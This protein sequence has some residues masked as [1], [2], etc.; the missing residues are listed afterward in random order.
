[1]S[2]LVGWI[3][4]GLAAS[5]GASLWPFRRGLLGIAMNIGAGMAGAVGLAYVGIALGLPRRDPLTLV[6]AGVGA[7]VM[8]VVAHG[9]WQAGTRKRNRDAPEM[10]SRP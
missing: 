5:L 8:L 1:M 3:F 9:I 6:F 7:F 2:Y 4:I 10:L